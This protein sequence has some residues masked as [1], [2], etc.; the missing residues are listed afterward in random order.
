M[1][2]A[3]KKRSRHKIYG[4]TLKAPSGTVSLSVSN[5]PIAH[6][7]HIKRRKTAGE[8]RSVTDWVCEAIREKIARDTRA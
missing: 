1:G 4:A 3:T 6:H 8:C 2:A 7:E 5:L